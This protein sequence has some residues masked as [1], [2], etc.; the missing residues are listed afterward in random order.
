MSRKE[1][2]AKAEGFRKAA[3]TKTGS[4]RAVLLRKARNYYAELEMSGMVKWC[5]K[6][7][8]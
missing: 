2:K 7:I 5:E 8:G 3:E 1:I 4:D 6:H